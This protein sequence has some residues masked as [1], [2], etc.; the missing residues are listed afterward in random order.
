SSDGTYGIHPVLGTA[1]F[2]RPCCELPTPDASPEEADAY[3]QFLKAY[4]SDQRHHL[5]PIAIRLQTNSG[6]IRAEALMLPSDEHKVSAA[7][8]RRLGNQPAA[9]DEL[10][11]SPRSVFS[12]N[13]CLNREA[14]LPTS[15]K[16][17][18][19]QHT[20]AHAIHLITAPTAPF[21]PN[22]LLAL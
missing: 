3:G 8:A 1:L 4:E 21:Y 7:L 19:L 15:S 22:S 12:V 17:A 14:Y 16:P 5:D 6:R 20:Q 18:R 13:L 10:P 9:L 2:L 11:I